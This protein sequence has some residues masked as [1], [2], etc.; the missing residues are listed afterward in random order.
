[1]IE[2]YE[3]SKNVVTRILYIKVIIGK[4]NAI[5]NST[6]TITSSYDQPVLLVDSEY[7]EIERC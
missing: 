1:M 4:Y 3:Y 6:R 5:F 7:N 2:K